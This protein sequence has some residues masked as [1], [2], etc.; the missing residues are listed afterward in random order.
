[1]HFMHVGMVKVTSWRIK[2]VNK[3]DLSAFE[4]MM[5]VCFRWVSVSISEIADL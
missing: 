3:D 1:M 2:M 5:V 4:V